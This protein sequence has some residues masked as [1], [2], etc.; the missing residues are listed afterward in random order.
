MGKP[1]VA[2]RPIVNQPIPPALPAFPAAPPAGG[3]LQAPNLAP[4]MPPK[5]NKGPMGNALRPQRGW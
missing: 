4:P 3:W 5:P 2:G 1:A